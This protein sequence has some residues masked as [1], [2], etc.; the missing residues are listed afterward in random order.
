MEKRKRNLRTRYIICSF[1]YEEKA[2]IMVAKGF[3]ENRILQIL[4]RKGSKRCK[5]GTL[6]NKDW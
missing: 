3:E 4:E 5:E 6:I 1:Q 2:Q